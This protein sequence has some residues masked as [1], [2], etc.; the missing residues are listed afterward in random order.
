LDRTFQIYKSRFWVFVGIAAL[1]A[2]VMTGLYLADYGWVHLHTSFSASN[3]LATFLWHQLVFLGYY[4]VNFCIANLI[5][6]AA[7]RQ[8]ADAVV[9]AHGTY[10]ASLRFVTARWRSYLWVS[11]LK[12]A[13]ILVAPEIAAAGIIGV[14]ILIAA[15]IG[16]RSDRT[17]TLLIFSSI[18]MLAAIVCF[19][20][21]G[22]C[23]SFAVPAAALEDLKGIRSM[24]RSWILSR[25][26]RTRIAI[27]WLLVFVIT[28][29]LEWGAQYVLGLIVNPLYTKIHEAI[30]RG[31]IIASLYGVNSIVS[32][33]MGPIYPIAVTL[34]YYDQ[35]IRNEGY[36]IEQMMQAAGWTT[37]AA[38]VNQPLPGPEA[39]PEAHA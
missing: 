32:A 18:C 19:F 36:D 17:S 13:A 23:F 20:W 26:T 4:H 14:G 2:L 37:V 16:S 38:Q 28:L 33:F 6:P 35:R 29:A 5:Y 7:V 34:F 22:S 27:V 31:A 3:P 10:G 25:G 21:L 39:L 9:G 1:P 8:C 30:W 11:I 12:L 15:G 24:R